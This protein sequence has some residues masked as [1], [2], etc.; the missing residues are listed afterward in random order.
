M[1]PFTNFKNSRSKIVH[2]SGTTCLKSLNTAKQVVQGPQ[3]IRIDNCSR[4]WP[5]V[6]NSRSYIVHASGTTCLKSLKTAKK[7]VWGPPKIDVYQI[8]SRGWEGGGRGGLILIRPRRK[9]KQTPP[10]RNVDFHIPRLPPLPPPARTAT[11][12]NLLKRCALVEASPAPDQRRKS[13]SPFFN[14]AVN[15]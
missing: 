2:A 15:P 4:F 5:V 14:P 6:E 9:K 12:T 8:R 1:F 10:A 11:C 7:L 13:G 3:K